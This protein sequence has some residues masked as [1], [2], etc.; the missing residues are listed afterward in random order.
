MA[1][2]FPAL[3]LMELGYTAKCSYLTKY[4]PER[5]VWDCNF[6]TPYRQRLWDT[7]QP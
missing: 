2:Y 7:C 4:K 6:T 3:Y 1:D 5:Q